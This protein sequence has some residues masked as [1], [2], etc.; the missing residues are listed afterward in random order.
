MKVQSR[1][2]SGSHPSLLRASINVTSGHR[3]AAS[4]QPSPLHW[5]LEVGGR[6]RSKKF[7][8][9]LETDFLFIAHCPG[10]VIWPLPAIQEPE[11][12]CLLF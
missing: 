5:E 4:L 12:C 8:S 2:T 1:T 9:I 11:T 6:Q 10:E 3:M 7:I